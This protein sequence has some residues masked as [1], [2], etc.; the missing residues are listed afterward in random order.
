MVSV[1]MGGDQ[2]FPAIEPLGQFQCRFVSGD[3]VNGFSLGEALHHVVELNAVHLVVEIF[4]GEEVT[5]GCIGTTVDTG[6][7]LLTLPHGLLL[8][9]GVVHDRPHGAGGLSAF[10]VGKRNDSHRITTS[11]APRS[12][13]GSDSS[14]RV[15]G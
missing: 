5:E 12:G 6:D 10:V 7:E 13:A 11:F 15:P 9:H 3:R 14:R 2:N 8:L 4:C 1:H